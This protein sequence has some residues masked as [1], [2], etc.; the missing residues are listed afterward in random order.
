[1]KPTGRVPSTSTTEPTLRSRISSAISRTGS[2]G[3]RGDHRLR[4][5]LAHQHERESTIAPTVAYRTADQLARRRRIEAL[6]R[7]AAPAL[8]LVLYAGDRVSRVVGPQR[9]RARAGA[10]AG[11]SA[12]RRD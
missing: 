10:R 11:S 9:A 8:D 3:L 2:A 12:R 5:D 1:M 4:H 6:I 7:L